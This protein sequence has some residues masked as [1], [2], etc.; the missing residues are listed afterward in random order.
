MFD[1][2]TSEIL[3]LGRPGPRED[4]LEAI[5]EKYAKAGEARQAKLV[6]DIADAVAKL[7]RAADGTEGVTA[8]VLVDAAAAARILGVTVNALRLRTQR[9]QMPAGSIVRTGRRVQ[10][11]TEA[12]RSLR[13]YTKRSA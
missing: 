2:R 4:V 12:L 6:A 1:E 7:M 5:R 3:G 11:K 10:F 9:G 13:P 8:P